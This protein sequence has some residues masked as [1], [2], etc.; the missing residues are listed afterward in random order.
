M[1]ELSLVRSLL[2]QVE[3]IACAERAS[4]VEYVCVAL[5]PLSG[6]E[7]L[8]IRSAFEQLAPATA[9]AGAELVVDEIP[10]TVLCLDCGALFDA[11]D[12]RFHCPECGS[13][14][15]R[16]VSGEEFRLMSVTIRESV[17]SDN[18]ERVTA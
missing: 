1:H 12:F 8:L 10:L 17:S 15:T 18:G 7:P 11:A 5:G 4:G 9:A 3:E 14:Q 2:Q 13:P 16:V 6:V